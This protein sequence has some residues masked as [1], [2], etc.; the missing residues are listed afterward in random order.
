MKLRNFLLA[1]AT[2]GAV[3]TAGAESRMDSFINSLMGKMT[4]EEKIGQLN[5]PVSGILDRKSVV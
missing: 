5:L 1:F 3:L 4:L 2:A